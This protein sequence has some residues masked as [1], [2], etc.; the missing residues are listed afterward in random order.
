MAENLHGNA[1]AARRCGVD[2]EGL[3]CQGRLDPRRRVHAPPAEALFIA[4]RG[5]NEFLRQYTTRKLEQTEAAST[6]ALVTMPTTTWSTVL[7]EGA[8]LSKQSEQNLSTLLNGNTELDDV[9]RALNM[10]EVDSLYTHSPVARTFSWLHTARLIHAC[11]HAWLKRLEDVK[12]CVQ[13]PCRDSLSRF[14]PSDVS[15]ICSAALR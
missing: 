8:R 2:F 12:R 9:A 14:R 10:L 7:K 11:V 6:A 13:C 3:G 1:S 15:P 5:K 4:E